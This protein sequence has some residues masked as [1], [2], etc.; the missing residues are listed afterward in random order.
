MLKTEK[1]QQN[2]KVMI[3]YPEFK[4]IDLKLLNAV[5]IVFTT[6]HF[7]YTYDIPIAQSAINLR[8]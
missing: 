6:I 4:F 3:S 5:L 8:Y 7:E 2:K 1:N